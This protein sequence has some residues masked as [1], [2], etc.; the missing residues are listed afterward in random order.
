MENTKLCAN[1][2]NLE[3][4]WQWGLECWICVGSRH[5]KMSEYPLLLIYLVR[6]C[7]LQIHRNNLYN[8]H[9]THLWSLVCWAVLNGDFAVENVLRIHICCKKIANW[10]L[11]IEGSSWCDYGSTTSAYRV[12]KIVTCK[13]T[14]LNV[15]RSSVLV[16]LYFVVI[17]VKAENFHRQIRIW[18]L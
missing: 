3:S 12:R 5:C 7:L 15:R 11:F 6:V 13:Y 4:L 8:I 10:L 18:P 14:E 17:R 16:A 9:L 2:K 1:H